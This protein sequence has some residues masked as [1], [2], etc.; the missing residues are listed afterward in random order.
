MNFD[1]PDKMD[2]NTMDAN[3]DGVLTFGEWAEFATK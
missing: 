2:F 3:E 1:C